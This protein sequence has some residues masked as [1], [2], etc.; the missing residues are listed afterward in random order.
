M[1]EW[2]N[3]VIVLKKWGD[4]RGVDEDEKGKGLSVGCPVLGRL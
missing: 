2:R 4:V 1:G 3:L